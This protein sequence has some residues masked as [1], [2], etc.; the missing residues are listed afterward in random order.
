MK[1]KCVK[2]DQNKEE[3]TESSPKK[4]ETEIPNEGT[5]YEVVQI[6]DTSCNKI[7]NARNFKISSFEEYDENG[8]I[9]MKKSVEFIVVGSNRTWKLFV[10]YDDFKKSNPQVKLPGDK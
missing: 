1:G 9:N 10:P 5:P 2:M 8:K 7:R 6:Y 3:N 4:E